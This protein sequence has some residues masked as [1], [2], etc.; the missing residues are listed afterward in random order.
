M[1][2]VMIGVATIVFFITRVI[3]ADPVGAIL[4]AAFAYLGF[5]GSLILSAFLIPAPLMRR[6]DAAPASAHQ[7]VSVGFIMAL[8]LVGWA[9]FRIGVSLGRRRY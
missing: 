5:I 9:G 3:P 4:G 1:L 8:V 7:V 6:I 2:I